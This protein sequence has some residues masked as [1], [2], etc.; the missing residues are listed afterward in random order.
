MWSGCAA[1]H[2]PPSSAAVME[3]YSYTSTHPLGHTGPVTGS[4]YFFTIGKWVNCSIT[5]QAGTEGRCSAKGDGWLA[6]CP[7]CFTSG[8]ET[9]YPLYRRLDES[10]GHYGWVREISPHCG[11][12]TILSTFTKLLY[13]LRFPGPS[14]IA[15]AEKCKVSSIS[16]I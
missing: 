16:M 1:D 7:G 12:N 13:Q 9:Q 6:P 14:I 2:S 15:S 11:S 4:L 3:E 10:W 5:F 8:K